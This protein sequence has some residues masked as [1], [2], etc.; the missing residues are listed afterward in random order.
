MHSHAHSCPALILRQIQ[1]Y[2]AVAS[3]SS[4]D[5]PSSQQARGSVYFWVVLKPHLS[6]RRMESAV[7]NAL[8]SVAGG[9]SEAESLQLDRATLESKP[10]SLSLRASRGEDNMCVFKPGIARLYI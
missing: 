1:W 9:P 7:V 2:Q 8:F 4:V 5:H 6:R 10:S 3:V